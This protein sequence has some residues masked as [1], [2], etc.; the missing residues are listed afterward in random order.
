MVNVFG[1]SI[2]FRQICYED[3]SDYAPDERKDFQA[4]FSLNENPLGCSKKVLESIRNIDESEITEY[5]PIDKKLVDKIA[6]FEGV[7]P[8]NILVS[9]GSDKCIQLTST[10]LLRKGQKIAYPKPS[11][12]RYEFYIRRMECKKHPITLPIFG[13]RNI[14]RFQK[15]PDS[16]LLILDNPS[17]PMGLKF[18]QKELENLVTRNN[19]PVILDMALTDGAYQ[20]SNLLTE[21]TFIVK[22]FSKYLGL[23]G[24]RIGYIISTE[25]NIRKLK[26]LTSPFEVTSIAQ[27]AA[28][29][30]LEDRK[31]LRETRK[32]VSRQRRKIK[33]GLDKLSIQYS[34]SKSTNMVIELPLD[35]QEKLIQEGIN[36]T[37]GIK[38]KGLP[39]NTARIGIRTQKEND[40]LLQKIEELVDRNNPKIL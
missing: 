3:I 12:P 31:H 17:N 18:S 38:F 28:K 2:S 35:M 36:L 22:S 1:D 15:L 23:P 11:F 5:Q 21:N 4:D 8:E 30:A 14:K 33:S 19:K 7:N 39:Q 24:L 25:E 27:L 20:V 6:E 32:H 37:K 16:D 29:K 13:S 34:D 9:A 10:A 40:L 26:S